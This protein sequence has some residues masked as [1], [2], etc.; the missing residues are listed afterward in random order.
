MAWRPRR[1]HWQLNGI[2]HATARQVAAKLARLEVLD[3]LRYRDVELEAKAVDVTPCHTTPAAAFFRCFLLRP[4]RWPPLRPP[5][6]GRLPK[7]WK[8][9]AISIPRRAPDGLDGGLAQ[10]ETEFATL[11]FL[12]RVARDIDGLLRCV[13]KGERHESIPARPGR[14]R[15]ADGELGETAAVPSERA[16]AG[17]DGASPP[18]SRAV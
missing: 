17:G 10:F 9:A 7:L 6:R 11:T 8:S 14:V 16:R 2:G 15:A 3:G 13:E 1:G 4:V 18:T 12:Q 5:Q